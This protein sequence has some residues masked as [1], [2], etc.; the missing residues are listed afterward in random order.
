MSTRD[1]PIP[2]LLF[3]RNWP[4]ELDIFQNSKNGSPKGLAGK[5]PVVCSYYTYG[6]HQYVWNTPR[7]HWNLFAGMQALIQ[8][9]FGTH[10]KNFAHLLGLR[11]ENTSVEERERR[12]RPRKLDWKQSLAMTLERSIGSIWTQSNYFAIVER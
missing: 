3:R 6:T 10:P 1:I 8:R 5:N 4:R 2:P 11:K 12:G 9:N 7:R